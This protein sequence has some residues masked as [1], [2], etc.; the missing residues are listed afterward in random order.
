MSRTP[1]DKT[2]MCETEKYHSV[3]AYGR[4]DTKSVE[5]IVH[6]IK[7]EC[8][9]MALAPDKEKL[10]LKK[11]TIEHIATDEHGDHL[12]SDTDPKIGCIY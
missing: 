7:N 8:I 6:P 3:V 4:P 1:N 9:N 10:R 12:S 2:K 11:T 5:S